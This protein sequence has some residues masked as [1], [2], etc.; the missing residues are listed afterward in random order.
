MTHEVRPESP[1]SSPRRQ[2]QDERTLKHLA[3]L[4]GTLRSR[5]G[6]PTGQDSDPHDSV[7]ASSEDSL[8]GVRRRLTFEQN[9]LF[10]FQTVG[11][12]GHS[13]EDD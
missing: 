9:G 13:S 8:G 4:S 5:L 12:G 2:S 10:G 6:S 1:F 7:D 3:F 11:S